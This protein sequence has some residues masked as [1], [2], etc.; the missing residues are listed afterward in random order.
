MVKI[1]V[2]AGVLAVTGASWWL[3]DRSSGTAGLRP[4][5]ELPTSLTAPPARELGV[6]PSSAGRTEAAVDGPAS[7]PGAAVAPPASRPGEPVYTKTEYGEPMT[8]MP[9]GTVIIQRNV[10]VVQMSDGTRK[11]VPAT[12]TAR[13]VP[14]P[15][16]AVQRGTGAPLGG[17]RTPP[18]AGNPPKRP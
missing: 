5:P 2:I 10:S 13:P 4:S 6:G 8:I 7:K 17:A 9:D 11:E 3:I 14:K 18:S 1:V 12:I 15:L 16:T